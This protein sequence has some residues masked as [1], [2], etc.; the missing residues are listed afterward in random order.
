ML[1]LITVLVI[2]HVEVVQRHL[3]DARE[4]DLGAVAHLG[5]PIGQVAALFTGLQRFVY[6]DDLLEAFAEVAGPHLVVYILVPDA[7]VHDCF[8]LHAAGHLVQNVALACIL[9]QVVAELVLEH[10]KEHYLFLFHVWFVLFKCL[11]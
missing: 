9:R 7:R 6:V 11:L 10:L 5:Y 8:T 3:P 2:L 4:Q 1:N